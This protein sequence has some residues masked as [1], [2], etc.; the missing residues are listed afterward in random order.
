MAIFKGTIAEL[1]SASKIPFIDVN[2]ELEDEMESFTNCMDII[3]A[4]DSAI[5]DEDQYLGDQQT[6]HEDTR[7]RPD[8]ASMA[9]E[10]S[11]EVIVKSTREEYERYV[12]N[13]H[14]A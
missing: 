14:N 11:E 1:E 13:T 10:A 2:V 7:Y 12:L 5:N 9:K 6:E 3:E 4:E 8:F